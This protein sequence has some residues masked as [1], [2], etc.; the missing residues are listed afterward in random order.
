M[1]VSEFLSWR[2][3]VETV[4]ARVDVEEKGGMEVG[5]RSDGSA[6]GVPTVLS[7]HHHCRPWNRTFKR[8]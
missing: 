8:H 7:R 6:L 4:A 2:T 1:G 5:G 3:F